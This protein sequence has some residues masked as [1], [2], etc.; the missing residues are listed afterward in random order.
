MN[1]SHS[2]KKTVPITIKQTGEQY[3]SQPVHT[4]KQGTSN[5]Q[6]NPE[7]TK[8][9]EPVPT[10]ESVEIDTSSVTVPAA[11]TP[12]SQKTSRAQ[13]SIG[14]ADSTASTKRPT[15]RKSE[16]KP[17][18]EIKTL[19]Q[20]IQYAYK[21]KGKWAKLLPKTEKLLA[22]SVVRM[23][24]AAIERL[25]T[26]ASSDE[27]LIVPRQLLLFSRDIR[28]FPALASKLTAFVLEVMQRHPIFRASEI[29][30]VLRNLPDAMQPKDAIAKV[31]SFTPILTSE[32]ETTASKIV[33]GVSHQN[34]QHN[35]IQLL[36]TWLAIHRNM[37][38]DDVTT[39]LL[40]AVWKP[41]AQQLM[42][43]NDR[44]RA[45]TEVEPSASAG[46][47]IACNQFWQQ[48]INKD[49]LYDQTL[50]KID[51]LNIQINETKVQQQQIEEQRN[52][53]ETELTAL[54]E[55]AAS[56]ITKLK[57]QHDIEYTHLRYDNEKLCGRLFSQLEKSV[58]ML[59]VG[60]SALRNKTP[61]I[62]AMIE[63]AEYVSD[64]LRIEMKHLSKV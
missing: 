38:L 4:N 49:Q 22:E 25:L 31:A 41:A 20:F 54:H 50:Q 36:V 48:A 6:T 45:L 29:N 15:K 37:R 44:L 8:K 16:K 3:H 7:E 57:E 40:Q 18:P 24:R 52:A 55:S 27:L 34:L 47:G 23:D 12:P 59:E 33:S 9:T 32:D 62:Q 39:L 35:A 11:E 14:L 43:D 53:L 61:S 56:E 1:K 17:K 26:I 2:A 42:D 10:P 64:T 21:R 19:E 58:D 63:R 28:G 46:V 60:L 13:P 30:G 5:D 51:A